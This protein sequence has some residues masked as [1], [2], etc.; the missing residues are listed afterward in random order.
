[1]IAGPDTKYMMQWR[2]EWRGVVNMWDFHNVPTTLAMR[3][4]K[5]VL[6]VSP[7]Y[8]V[9]TLVNPGEIV[10]RYDRDPKQRQWD[11]DV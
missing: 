7:S 9:A 3:A 8:W 6:Y 4:V 11:T 2:G 10:E 1:M 5:A